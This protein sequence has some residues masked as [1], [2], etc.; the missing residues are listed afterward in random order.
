[1]F[2]TPECDGF[3]VDAKVLKL[4]GGERQESTCNIGYMSRGQLIQ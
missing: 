1:M 4:F 3:S 2:S